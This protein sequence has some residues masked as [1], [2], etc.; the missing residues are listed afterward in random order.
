[1]NLKCNKKHNVCSL[2]SLTKRIV[3]AILSIVAFSDI[4]IAAWL[5]IVMKVNVAATHYFSFS[6]L[7]MSS[8]NMYMWKGIRHY[9]IMVY[10]SN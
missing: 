5:G 2:F 9:K 10:K 8:S 1:M 4:F 6:Y 7:D 3:K